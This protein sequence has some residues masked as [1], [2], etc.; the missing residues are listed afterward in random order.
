MD[1]GNVH[2]E[3]D[4]SKHEEWQTDLSLSN[5]QAWRVTD[6]LEWL[7]GSHEAWKTVCLCLSLHT[8][9]R[10]RERNLNR[11]RNAHTHIWRNCGGWRRYGV[12]WEE[13]VM[14]WW[15][16]YIQLSTISCNVLK[17]FNVDG[18]ECLRLKIDSLSVVWIKKSSMF[19]DDRDTGET[20]ERKRN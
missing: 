5:W 6:R 2:V 10:G 4:S 18:G 14:K 17:C 16:K 7:T 3:L 20:G 8:C 13:I 19:D 15:R 9:E 12:S 1:T 11:L